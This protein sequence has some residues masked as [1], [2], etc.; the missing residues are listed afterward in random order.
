MAARLWVLRRCDARKLTRR[1]VH[2][3]KLTIT[4]EERRGVRI[5]RVAGDLDNDSDLLTEVGGWL[6]QG[7]PPIVIAL[8]DVPYVNSSGL[9]GLVRLAAQ[10]NIMEQK[11]ALAD[12]SAFLSGLLNVTRLDR[13]FDVYAS[14]DEAVEA[15]AG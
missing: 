10:A 15:L 12:P 6:A 9:S 3:C 14:T 7:G 2:R 1:D 13:F 8:R 5:A 11:L 4:H